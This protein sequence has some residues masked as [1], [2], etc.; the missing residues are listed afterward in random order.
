[1]R[2]SAAIFLG[3]LSFS[4]SGCGGA[5]DSGG[6]TAG[7]EPAV[8]PLEGRWEFFGTGWQDDEC[9]AIEHIVEPTAF[10][11]SDVGED[12]FQ[13][14]VY[15]NASLV[16][17]QVSCDL[18]EDATY[19]CGAINQEWSVD[20]ATMIYLEATPSMGFSDEQSATGEVEVVLD[21]QGSGCAQVATTSNSGVFPCSSTWTWSAGFVE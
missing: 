9:N 19:A 6:D 1:M 2:C 12:S 10:I 13:M 7:D 21:C 14:K 11:T 16:G 17:Q 4:V 8:A 20:S 5:S 15:E 3:V 18:G